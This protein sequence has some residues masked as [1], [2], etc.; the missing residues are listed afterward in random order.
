MTLVDMDPFRGDLTIVRS[1][2]GIKAV[3]QKICISNDVAVHVLDI[4]VLPGPAWAQV[5]RPR[6]W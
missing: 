4:D 2:H 5:T 3:R 6:Y 1:P